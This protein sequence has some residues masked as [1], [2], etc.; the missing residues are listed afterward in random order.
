MSER[1]RCVP[2]PGTVTVIGAG[3][4][5][6]EAAFTAAKLGC[7][8]DLWEMRPDVMTPAHHTGDPAELVCSNSL[9]N[10]D[11]QK[12]AG[13]LKAELRR[14]GSLLIQAADATTVPAGQALAVDRKKFSQHVRRELDGN[15]LI[16]WHKGEVTDIDAGK[17]T[18][19]ATGPLTSDRL[20]QKIRELIGDDFLYFFDAASPIVTAESLDLEIIYAASRRMP[21]RDDYLNCP[22]GRDEYLRFREEL[23]KAEPAPVKDFERG[24]FYEGCLPI[25]ELA[26]RGVDTMR[27]GPLK[28]VGLPDPRTGREPY[29]VVQ[30]RR[31]DREG[32]LY[33]MVGF[34]T[35]LK[36]GEQ[37]R[38]F[39]MIPGLGGAGFVRYGVMHRN[40]YVN[41]PIC[42]LPTLQL[43]KFPNVLLAGQV[44][45]VEGYVEC[46]ATGWLAGLNASLIG[47]GM[48]PLELPPESALGALPASIT[49][50]NPKN[51]QP[52][53]INLGLLLS[54]LEKVK[55]KRRRNKEISQRSAE[56]LEKFIAENG[57][58]FMQ[59]P[60]WR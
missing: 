22:L 34:Q 48:E 54:G 1:D 3:L 31:E 29:A 47:K 26:L 15:P 19:L 38:V 13:I 24:R 25:E 6:S 20:A 43:K 58:C 18:V 40:I 42:L 55:D 36:W 14:V 21:G 23:I 37:K 30:L 52:V 57:R 2:C 27:F 46:I 50:G 33:S 17:L 4:A 35:R 60:S 39:S 51:F 41:A 5:G 49:A 9:G 10:D 56:S 11:P 32:S 12:A 28:P 7:H 53:N 44:T 16:S 59:Q 45:G 8:V